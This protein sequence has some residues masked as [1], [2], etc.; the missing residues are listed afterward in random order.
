MK[1]S[2]AITYLKSQ[3]KTVA[4]LFIYQT[5]GVFDFGQLYVA[6]SR[7][8]SLEGLVLKR[9]VLAKDLRVDRRVH[10]FLAQATR[11]E[12]PRRY[13]AVAANFVGREDRMSRPRPV[14]IAIVFEDRSEVC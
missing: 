3:V 12:A 8:T 4:R 11:S 1:Y 14:E 10:R 13:C 9:P 5:G 7:C 2:V 6:L